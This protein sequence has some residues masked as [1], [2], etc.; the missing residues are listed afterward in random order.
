MPGRPEELSPD[1]RDLRRV[2]AGD[3]T[4]LDGLVDRHAAAVHRYVRSLTSDADRAED[5]LQETFI[6]AWR[7]AGT[8]R[9]D[10]SARSW[11]LT[12]ARN[13]VHRQ[14]R[15]RAGEP[16]EHEDLSALAREA[17][18]GRTPAFSRRLEARDLVERAME[19]LSPEDREILILRDAEG[20][21]G[22]EA[23]EMLGITL[24]AQKSRLHRARLRFMARV[25]EIDTEVD[26]GP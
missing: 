1:A 15:R 26:H 14:R 22:E 25:R 23:A 18:W 5:A 2:A 10:G 9:G 4:A 17:G 16:A 7:S 20:T 6:A 21:S 24:A 3:R 11:L 19:G 8:F 13:A 12:I